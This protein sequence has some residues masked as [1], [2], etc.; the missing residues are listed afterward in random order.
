MPGLR[1]WLAERRWYRVR[2]T[3]CGKRRKDVDARYCET[4]HWVRL[5]A[6]GHGDPHRWAD[7]E[8]RVKVV[9]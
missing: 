3:F 6:P 7:Q 5:T 1:G 8:R 2:C 4:A 9:R